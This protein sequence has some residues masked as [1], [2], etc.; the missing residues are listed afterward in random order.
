MSLQFCFGFSQPELVQV[1]YQVRVA[2]PMAL[3]FL[4]RGSLTQCGLHSFSISAV[5]SV[6]LPLFSVSLD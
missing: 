5:L 1:V 6:C 3:Q 4:Q 2:E